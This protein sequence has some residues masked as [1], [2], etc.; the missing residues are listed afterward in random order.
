MEKKSISYE[1]YT[2]TASPRQVS[3]K[4]MWTVDLVIS[5]GQGKDLESWLISAGEQTEI[6]DGALEY[7]FNFGKQIID[8]EM[9]E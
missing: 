4:D 1:G 2:I 7:C 9:K 8:T 3:D 5:R 6:N